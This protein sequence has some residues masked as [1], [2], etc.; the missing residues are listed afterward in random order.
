MELHVYKS[1]SWLFLA[2]EFETE[3]WYRDNFLKIFNEYELNKGFI[4][5][6]VPIAYINGRIL[7]YVVFGDGKI[8]IK[9]MS[10]LSDTVVE[11]IKKYKLEVV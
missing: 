3:N 10:I 11:K 5:E 1:D 2:N 4:S 8:K 9:R 6:N 7:R